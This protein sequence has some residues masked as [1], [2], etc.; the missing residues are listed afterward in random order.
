MNEMTEGVLIGRRRIK[1][2]A[3]SYT[4]AREF[5]HLLKQ[6]SGSGSRKQNKNVVLAARQRGYE[7]RR[8]LSMNF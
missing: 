1:V 8:D 4:C 7:V 3:T 5:P 2:N 6:K